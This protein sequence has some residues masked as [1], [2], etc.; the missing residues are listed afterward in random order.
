MAVESHLDVPG[1]LE[2]FGLMTPPVEGEPAQEKGWVHKALA[3]SSSSLA[4]A[5]I[6][7]KALIPVRVPITL[8]LTPPVAKYVDFAFYDGCY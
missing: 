4:L 6:A 3:G 8:G 7:N 1:Y 5:F 2:K